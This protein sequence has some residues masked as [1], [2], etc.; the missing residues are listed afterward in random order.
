MLLQCKCII[1]LFDFVACVPSLMRRARSFVGNRVEFLNLQH[2]PTVIPA[3][4]HQDEKLPQHPAHRLYFAAASGIAD[5]ALLAFIQWDRAGMVPTIGKE[6]KINPV[7][8]W[9]KVACVPE[10]I[11][12]VKRH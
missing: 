7:F 12:G 2:D 4:V 10:I 3:V 5:P 8:F 6:Q 11:S 1:Y 9:G